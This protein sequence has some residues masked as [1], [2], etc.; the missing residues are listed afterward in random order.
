[1]E[2]LGYVAAVATGVAAVVY[3]FGRSRQLFRMIE[4]A[5]NLLNTE[6]TNNSG[7]SMK[8]SVESAADDLHGIA[9]AVGRLQHHVDNMAAQVEDNAVTLADVADR[10]DAVEHQLSEIPTTLEQ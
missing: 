3:I 6:L 10:I 5:A 8:D 9:V 2:V 7:S 1:M 4:R